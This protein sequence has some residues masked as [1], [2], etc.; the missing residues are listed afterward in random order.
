VR[1]V[2]PD[3]VVE[4]QVAAELLFD[5]LELEEGEQWA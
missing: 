1:A 4:A 2:D 5:D 3:A